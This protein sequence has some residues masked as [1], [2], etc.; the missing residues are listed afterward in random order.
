MHL[1]KGSMAKMLNAK[2]TLNFVASIHNLTHCACYA[3]VAQSYS[4]PEPWNKGKQ[5]AI[6]FIFPPNSV[7][8]KQ[9]DINIGLNAFLLEESELINIPIARSWFKNEIYYI[10]LKPLTANNIK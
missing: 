5:E 8:L 7:S 2:S 1:P 6:I 4:E 9:G 10:E 3:D